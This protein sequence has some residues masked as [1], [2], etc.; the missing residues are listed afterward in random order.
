M[1]NYKKIAAASLAVLMTMSF[2]ACGNGGSE[3]TDTTADITTTSK[4]EWTGDN[5]EVSAEA[6]ALSTEVVI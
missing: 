2:A 4:T 6:G 1:K 5:I 3:S